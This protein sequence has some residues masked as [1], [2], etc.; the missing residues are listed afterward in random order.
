MFWRNA[1]AH[2]TFLHRV[3]AAIV[4]TA[5]E[6]RQ[7]TPPSPVTQQWRSRQHWADLALYGAEGALDKARQMLPALAV[8]ANDAGL[9]DETGNLTA[10]DTQIRAILTNTWIDLFTRYVPEV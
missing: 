3:A 6:L 10:T 4:E 9:L 2:A 5:I 7:E 8:K 1:D